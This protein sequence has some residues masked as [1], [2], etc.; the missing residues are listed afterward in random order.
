[1]SYLRPVHLK[2]TPML[3]VLDGLRLRLVPGTMRGDQ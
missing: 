2:A 1:M 3:Q